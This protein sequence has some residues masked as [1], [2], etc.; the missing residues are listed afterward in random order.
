[1]SATDGRLPM[2]CPVLC[3][4]NACRLHV[5][6]NFAHIFRPYSVARTM[7]TTPARSPRRHHDS[8]PRHLLSLVTDRL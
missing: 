3:V 1:M 5:P 4:D 6:V 2:P 7:G 8:E